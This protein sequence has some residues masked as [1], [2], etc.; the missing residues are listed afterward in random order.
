MARKQDN[1]PLVLGGGVLALS[2][3]FHTTWSILFED[4]VKHQLEQFAGHAV[5]EMIDR[6]GDVGFR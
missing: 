6:F 3:I 1:L 4:W 2:V 5:A